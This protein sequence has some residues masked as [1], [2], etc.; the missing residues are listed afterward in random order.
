M[1]YCARIS[2]VGS[3]H[4]QTFRVFVWVFIAPGLYAARL[5]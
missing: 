4:V 3:D 1:N 5:W 2:R